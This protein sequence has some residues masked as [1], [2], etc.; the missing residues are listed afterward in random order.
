MNRRRG[1]TI[2]ELV[3]ASAV[4]ALVVLGALGIFSMLGKAERRSELR[5]DAATELARLHVAFQRAFRTIVTEVKPRPPRPTRAGTPAARPSTGTEPPPE[6]EPAPEVEEVVLTGPP[7]LNLAIDE[8]GRPKIEVMVAASPVPIRLESGPVNLAAL[9][10][11]EVGGGVWGKFELRP[12]PVAPT[13]TPSTAPRFDVYWS[14]YKQK[15]KPI[16]RVRARNR[17]DRSAEDSPEG[18]LAEDEAA[19][20]N[21]EPVEPID[22]RTLEFLGEVVIA[23]DLV[24][25][26]V[27]FLATQEGRLQP[28]RT[29]SAR[30]AQDL[31]AYVH[32]TVE[33]KDGVKADWAFETLYVN[34]KAPHPLADPE[35][36]D[37]FRSS[38]SPAQQRSTNGS[39]NG[40]QNGGSGPPLPASS[41]G[42]AK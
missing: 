15:H 11:P 25:L 29:F 7:R 10:F 20:E 1:F 33:H 12:S 35:G 16:T 38:R 18:R 3:L 5:A 9:G 2:I 34:T 4:G 39:A 26:T 23:R 8:N 17:V 32:I 22:P 13:A 36:V 42:G 24:D 19:L 21:P 14:V 41:S 6:E 27:E 37:A 40:T 28:A 30:F 31:P